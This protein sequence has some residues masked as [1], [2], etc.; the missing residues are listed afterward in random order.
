MTATENSRT[1]NPSLRGRPNHVAI[2]PDGS[3]RWA[4][5]HKLPY[6]AAYSRTFFNVLPMVLDVLRREGVRA[7]TVW[8]FAPVHWG[9]DSAEIDMIMPLFER[10]CDFI[11]QD[12]IKHSTCIQFLGR[13][14]RLPAGLHAAMLNAERLTENLSS[15]V[16]NLAIDHGGVSELTV[17]RSHFSMHHRPSSE[18]AEKIECLPY[19]TAQL[20]PSP[21]LVF[22]TS[23]ARRL[24]GFM[25][26][27]TLYSELYFIDT[28]WP[29]IV[30]SDVTTALDWYSK[31][32]HPD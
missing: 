9:R 16:L 32:V 5:Q 13:R 26:L 11:Q 24:S 10:F 17:L 18:T 14:D 2:L 27:N 30:E 29:D 21:D 25:P 31:Q 15:G 20:H 23:G 7:V 28:L 19:K 4:R 8:L 3:R 6:E 22:R 1:N 12:A